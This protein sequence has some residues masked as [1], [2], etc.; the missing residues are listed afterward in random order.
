[1][2]IFTDCVCSKRYDGLR[3]NAV[4]SRIVELILIKKYILKL[5]TSGN[6]FYTH[7]D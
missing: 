4:F 3:C 5:V 1:M 7:E 6:K 2:V